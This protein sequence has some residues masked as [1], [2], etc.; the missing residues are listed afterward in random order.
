MLFSRLL[1]EIKTN[2]LYI[3]FSKYFEAHIVCSSSFFPKL[4]SHSSIFIWITLMWILFFF[5]RKYFQF[6][7]IKTHLTS[8]YAKNTHIFRFIYF[9]STFVLLNRNGWNEWHTYVHTYIQTH[10]ERQSILGCVIAIH[11]L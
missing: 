11:Q 9:V 2:I 5:L 3:F 8:K 7:L 6:C 10:N 1:F 4:F